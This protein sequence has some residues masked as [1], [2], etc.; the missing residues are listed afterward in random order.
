[1]LRLTAAVLL[2]AGAFVGCGEKDL[3]DDD[4]PSRD[5]IDALVELFQQAAVDGDDDA[6]CELFTDSFRENLATPPT[7][8]QPP[9]PCGLDVV[10]FNERPDRESLPAA[11]TVYVNIDRHD[12]LAEVQLDNGTRLML[13]RAGESADGEWRIDVVGYRPSPETWSDRK[14]DYTD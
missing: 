10:F 14:F 5:Q 8:E 3:I 12:Q 13:R 4:L 7:T 9:S 1:M 2:A 6:A 11:G